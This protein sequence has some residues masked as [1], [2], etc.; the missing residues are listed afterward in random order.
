MKQKNQIVNYI[1]L[2]AFAIIFPVSIAQEANKQEV[3]VPMRDGVKL[4][5]NL[6]LPEGEGP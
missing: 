6:Y 1:A 3:M 2:L 4:A 5:T